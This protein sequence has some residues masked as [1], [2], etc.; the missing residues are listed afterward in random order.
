MLTCILCLVLYSACRVLR[1][2]RVLPETLLIYRL[3]CAQ[4][5]EGV[6]FVTNAHVGKNV[7]MADVRASHDAVLLA[8]GATKPR[9]LPIP[10]TKTTFF[11][12][13]KNKM[14]MAAFISHRLLVSCE[15]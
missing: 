13:F 5:A 11:L 1:G 3:C 4:A 6:R 10:G 12:F 8:A 14:S 9:N 2:L 15:R 7:D